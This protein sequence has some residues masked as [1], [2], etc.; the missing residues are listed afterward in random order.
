MQSWDIWRLGAPAAPAEIMSSTPG[1]RAISLQLRAGEGFP[2]HQVHERAWV[3]VVDGEVGMRRA[4][5]DGDRVWWFP[6]IK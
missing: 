6:F 1:A 5:F 3:V 2:D 4:G